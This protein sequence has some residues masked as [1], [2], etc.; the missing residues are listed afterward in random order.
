MY[1]YTAYNLGIH[2]ELPLPELIPSDKPAD[3]VIRL[4][5]LNEPQQKRSDGGNY[6]LAK[7]AQFGMVLLKDG[8]EIVL[9]PNPGVD[10]AMIRTFLLGVIICVLLRQR[11]LL[12]LHA[13]S[14]VI[15]NSA[16]AFMADSGF[17]KST[18]AECFH[19][20]G[21]SILTDDVLAIQANKQQPLVIPGFP[22]IKLWPDAAASFGHLP[23]SLPLLHSQTVK[24]VHRLQDGFFKK[25]VPLKKIYVLAGGTHPEI[26]PL[27]PKQSFGELIRHSREMQALT[28]PEFLKEHFRQCTSVVQQVPIYSLRR[29]R[30]L[31]A[32]PELVKLV[33][34]DLAQENSSPITTTV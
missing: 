23:D 20:H 28:A 21:Y 1:V 12:V 2:S 7:I 3:V 34:N 32:L 18:L 14:V 11:G 13:S 33:E 5:K 8:N 9:D 6:L 4:G 17:G 31:A 27:E 30:S 10:E 16:V 19:A 15:N 24:R 25:A 22:Q 26:I 29:Q